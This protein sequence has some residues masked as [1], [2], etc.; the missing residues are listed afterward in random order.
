MAHISTHTV[1]FA[2]LIID[3]KDYGV[4][5]FVVQLR[6]RDGNILPGITIGD[7]G[8]KMGRDGIDN[9]WIQFK[10]VRVPR[11]QMLQKWA[12][13]S[14]EGV[15]SQPPK[16]QLAYGA[17]LGGRVSIIANCND[18]LKRGI[19]IAIRYCA[20]RRQ[21]ANKKGPETQILDYQTHQIRLLEP[22]AGAFAWTFA[23]RMLEGQAIKL[24]QDLANGDLTN[25]PDMHAT[26]AG[27]KAIS[28]WYITYALEQARQ[29]LAG[30]GYSAY[31]ALPMLVAD[32]AVNC[33]WEGDNTVMLLQTAQ[34]RVSSVFILRD[35]LLIIIFII[36]SSSSS[37]SRASSR[38]RS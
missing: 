25:L 27:L 15:Y 28:T 24:Q 20:V 37:P 30:H 22:L 18:L 2:R 12:K 33:S 32:M 14:R 1:C 34:V 11:D 29:C 21:F 19:T 4:H 38:A 9:G 7:C 3:G 35:R 36:C 31:A 13:V 23:A 8:K 26:S 16:A 6:D 17:L 10:N 5:S